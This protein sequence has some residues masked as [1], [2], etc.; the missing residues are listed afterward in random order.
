[1]KS[2]GGGKVLLFGK[3]LRPNDQPSL[4]KLVASSNESLT[5]LAD[6]ASVNRDA[7]Y[8]LSKHTEQA[9]QVTLKMLNNSEHWSTFSRLLE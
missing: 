8:L 9:I 2:P 4:K 3:T 5:E 6:M 1:M 7:L